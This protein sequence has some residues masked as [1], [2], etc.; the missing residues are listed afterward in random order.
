MSNVFIRP[1]PPFHPG[2]AGYNQMASEINDGRLV[3]GNGIKVTKTSNGTTI[4]LSGQ[5]NVS[6]MR[7]AGVYNFTS[8]YNVND[9]VYVDPNVTITDQDGNPIPFGM[10]SG[11]I[12]AGLWICTM[13]VP[14]LGIDDALLTGSVAPTLT[15]N[16]QQVTSQVADTFRH[17]D[18]N[19]YYPTYPLPG[20]TTYVTESS[21]TTIS[22]GIF[23]QPL[24]T[25]TS[26][27]ASTPIM[28][29]PVVELFDNYL[30]AGG[31]IT[32]LVLT[33]TG[34]GYTTGTYSLSISGG[35]GG[36]GA[37]FYL[38]SSSAVR[39]VVLTDA[40]YGYTS[41]PSVA[42]PSG[43]GTGASASANISGIVNVALPR[44]LQRRTYDSQSVVLPDNTHV[45]AYLGPGVR[46]DTTNDPIT[47]SL[48]SVA[49]IWPPYLPSSGTASNGWNIINVYTP[50]N[51]TGL[52]GSGGGPITLMEIGTERRWLV[53][54]VI[55]YGGQM[56]YRLNE[57]NPMATTASSD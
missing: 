5:G 26:G 35:G 6:D 45:Y 7:Y 43:G 31:Y 17:Y 27:S 47:G 28:E 14:A 29:L 37:G 36:G 49:L 24:A 33:G 44:Q 4:S 9:V 1:S 11:S 19:A 48:T 39:G 25:N 16:G 3:A 22:S 55:C 52:T 12:A 34:S 51:G 50:P 41:D 23:W 13:F 54:A 2:D 53:Q 42:F 30:T 21:W 57:N 10:G 46:S 38:C 56:A 32:S 15:A 40:G 18:L 8:S 20:G